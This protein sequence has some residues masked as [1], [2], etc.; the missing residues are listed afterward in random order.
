[1]YRSLGALGVGCTRMSI[2]PP[3]PHLISWQQN[4]VSPGQNMTRHDGSQPNFP[5]SLASPAAKNWKRGLGLIRLAESFL[6][7]AKFCSR[8]QATL[9][10]RMLAGSSLFK[11]L[12]VVM[13]YP[14][15]Q[16]SE[17]G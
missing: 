12:E 9:H 7:A 15:C 1:M 8:P 3:I 6:Q 13:L 16:L 4:D 11:P 17:V 10:P 14:V 5:R 2:K